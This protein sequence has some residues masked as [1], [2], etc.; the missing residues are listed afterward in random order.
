MIRES[1]P[2]IRAMAEAD[3]VGDIRGGDSFSDIYGFPRFLMNS[4]E[5]LAAILVHGDIVLLPQTY[6]PFSNPLARVLARWIISHSSVVL[7]RGL[8]DLNNAKLLIGKSNREVGYCPD[9]AFALQAERPKNVETYPTLP[10]GLKPGII[11]LNV[12]GLMYNGGYTRANMFDLKVD[13]RVLMPELLIALLRAQPNDLLLVPHTY[14]TPGAVESDLDSSLKIRDTLPEEFRNRIYA[15]IGNYD[16]H[17]LKGIIGN[18]DFFIGSR[19]HACIAALSQSI[20]CV[21]IAYSRSTLQ[22][23]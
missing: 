19:M 18:C 13:Y 8:Q 10:Q 20:P 22:Y 17:E 5:M 11:G 9:V 6:G 7:A 3:F 21:G 2:W 4:I 23:L 12:N 14:G 15:V 1:T 16:Q